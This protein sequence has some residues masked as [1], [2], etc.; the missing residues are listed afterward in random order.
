MIASAAGL[1]LGVSVAGFGFS[2]MTQAIKTLY[3]IAGDINAFIDEHLETLKVSDNLLVASTGRVLQAAKYGFGLGYISSVSIIAVGQYLLGNTLAAVATVATAAV[4]SNPVAM[5]CAALGAIYYGW[6]ALSEKER[7][8][9]LEK[10]SGGL[11][12][13]VELIR[14]LVEFVIRKSRD[15]M[16]P[17]QLDAFKEFVKSQAALFGKSLFDVTRRVGDLIKD[18]ADKSGELLK[19]GAAKASETA[20][21]AADA[22]GAAA[23]GLYDSVSDAGAKV[24]TSIKQAKR[25]I[26]NANTLVELPPAIAAERPPLLIELTQA[27]V[28]GESTKPV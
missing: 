16:T 22:L 24:A 17:G 11:S 23:K 14:S 28:A 25:R 27:P 21:Q 2:V 6:N 20:G 1:N 7:E 19:E 3:H 9:L 8:Q 18:G 10:L 15:L 12:I 4:L 5:T 13:G 26:G